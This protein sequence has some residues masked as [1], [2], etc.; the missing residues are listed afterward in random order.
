MTDP[1]HILQA[2]RIWVRTFHET[3]NAGITCRRCGITR[4][5]L[6]KWVRRF[7]A[8]GEAGLHSRSR[9]PHRLAS[10]KRTPELLER[11]SELRHKRNLGPRAFRLT[12]DAFML[13]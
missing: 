13:W 11:I 12:S 4:P 3:Q 1:P 9:R 6:R 2:R 7:E 5:T 10:S 8:Q